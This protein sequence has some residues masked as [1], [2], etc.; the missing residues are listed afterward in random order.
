MVIGLKTRN[1]ALVLSISVAEKFSIKV[2]GRVGREKVKA[3]C[4]GKMTE[5]KCTRAAGAKA[6]G[7]DLE[8]LISTL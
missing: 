7:T 4:F 3:L 1:M 5:L 2:N 8:L 6:R